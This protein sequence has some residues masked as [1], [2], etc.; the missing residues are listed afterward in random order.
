MTNPE[1]NGCGGKGSII[2]PPL[3]KFFEA[4]CNLHDVGYS[5]GGD[6]SR[7]F[8]CDAK[9]LVMMLKD[10]FKIKNYFNRVFHQFWAIIF[11]LA[12]RIFGKKYFNY[13]K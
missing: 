13:T 9:F 11:F 4:S 8:E 7:R 6:E 12:V 1:V 2:K 10:T 5:I 3:K